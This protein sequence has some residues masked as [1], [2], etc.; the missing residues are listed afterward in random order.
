MKKDDLYELIRTLTPVEKKVFKEKNAA[1]NQANFIRLFDAIATGEAANDADVKKKFSQEVFIN[2][3]C[4]TKA[5]L[6][7][8]ILTTLHE[9]LQPH[10]TRLQI[11]KLLEFAETLYSRKLSPQAEDVMQ[12]ALELAQQTDEVDLEQFVAWQL[13]MIKSKLHQK[14][15]LQVIFKVSERVEESKQYAQLFMEAHYA[16]LQRGKKE[17]DN[18]EKFYNHPLVLKKGKL[19]SA[20][21]ERYLAIIKSL[22]NTVA[23][24]YEDALEENIKVVRLAKPIAYTSAQ[25]EI[26]YINALFNVVLAQ[27][28]LH[29]SAQKYIEQLEKFEPVSMWGKSHHCVC[30]LRAKLNEY[31]TGKPTAEGKKLLQWIEKKLPQYKNELNEQELIKLHISIA[32][33]CLKEKEYNKALDYLLLFNQS[34]IARENRPVI[35]RVAMLY[36]QIAYYELKNFEWLAT[37]LRNYKYFQQTNDAFYLIEK[38]TLEFLS[39]AIRLPDDKTRKAAKAEFANNLKQAATKEHKSGMAYLENIGW[40]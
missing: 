16:Y 10:Y 32:G 36:Q 12:E 1:K 2:H 6:Y 17:E 9:Q 4:K 40:V 26:A 8:A 20:Q 7:E 22:L 31:V 23:K 19:K 27:Q 34:K 30:L 29:K 13:A 11:F 33:L 25:T 38:H 35:Y 28:S 39:K 15:N 3:L 14:D 37:T 5:Y 18:F 21:A 24:K